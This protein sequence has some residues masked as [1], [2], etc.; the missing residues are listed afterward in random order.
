[1]RLAE[2]K[3]TDTDQQRFA[4]TSGD[5]N[6]MH[7]D[8]LLARRTQAGSQVVHGIHL[9][10]W[11]LDA[12]AA[13]QPELPPLC[14]LRAQFSRFVYLNEHA[15]VVLMQQNSTRA[16]LSVSVNGI[17]RSKFTFEFGDVVGHVP[18]W[19]ETSLEEIAFAPS[20]PLASY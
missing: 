4:S 18:D 11:T 13:A 3:F 17:A 10:L 2:R 6:P 16:R 5:H 15:E 1:M 14:K 20:R 7:V 8:A 19:L 12:L 9:L